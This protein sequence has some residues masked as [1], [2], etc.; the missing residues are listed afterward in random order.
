MKGSENKADPLFS[1]RLRIQ[2][3]RLLPK[4]LSDR[5]LESIKQTPAPENRVLDMLPDAFHRFTPCQKAQYLEMKTYLPGYLLSS[6]GDR[7]LMAHSVEGRF[8]FLDHRLIEFFA[9][10]PQGMKIRDGVE[11]FLLK[12]T[13]E[14]LLPASITQRRKYPYRSPEARPLLA[15]H[16]L[17]PLIS[18]SE[19]KN[20]DVFRP[21]VVLRLANKLRS[22]P[23]NFNENM[24]MVIVFGMQIFCGL[25]R[26][27]FDAADSIPLEFKIHLKDQHG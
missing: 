8:P 19:L 20:H 15:C 25:C 5:A 23:N 17:A 22:F 10:L 3:G 16:N 24:V 4:F 12:K 6:Q 21:E 13:F 26:R 11:K 2:N 27:R 9:E 1:H 18:E 14:P 7:M